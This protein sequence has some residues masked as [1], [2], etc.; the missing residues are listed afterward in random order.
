M[1]ENEVLNANKKKTSPLVFALLSLVIILIGALVY[2]Y[3]NQNN[4]PSKS[5]T[6]D[7]DQVMEMQ[8]EEDSALTEEETADDIPLQTGSTTEGTAEANKADIDEDLKSFDSLDLSG[9]EDD[10]REDLISDLDD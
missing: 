10:Y 4:Q 5:L 9:V 1:E 3:L 2:M 8:L 7:K 6:E